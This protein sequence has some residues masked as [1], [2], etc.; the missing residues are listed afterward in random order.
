[1]RL[2]CP[3]TIAL[4]VPVACQEDDRA[5]TQGREHDII[6]HDAIRKGRG[7]RDCLQFWTCLSKATEP[8]SSIRSSA[9]KRQM[10]MWPL[11]R[12][13]FASQSMLPETPS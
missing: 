11:R 10:P 12:S 13:P 6:T 8:T 1:M 4:V 2:R 7:W 5:G 9:V 3:G